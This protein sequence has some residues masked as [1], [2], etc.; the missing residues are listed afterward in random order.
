MVSALRMVLKSMLNLVRPADSGV[1]GVLLGQIRAQQILQLGKLPMLSDAGFCVT[2]QTDED[3]I[4]SWLVDRLKVA[5]RTFIEFGVSHYREANTRY[6][7]KSR[8]W[9]GLVIDG[10]P[11]NIEIIRSDSVSYMRDLLAISAFITRDNINALIAQAG[12]GARVGLLSTDID[13][14]DYWVLERVDIEADIVVVEYNDFLGRLPV[15]VPYSPD[16]HRL[17]KSPHGTYWGASLAAFRHLLESRG[18]LFVG[19]NLIG[20]NAFF[21][22]RDHAKATRE[23]L[24]AFVAHPCIMREA[25][26]ADGNLAYK[27]YSAFAA[28]IGGLPL[29]RVDTGEQITV[30]D[31]IG[32]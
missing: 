1:T 25:R 7:L 18:Y 11:K 26:E 19:T 13:G 15:S 20:V 22:H 31:A 2:S 4:L 12:F 16:F 27:P 21:V 28:E 32:A 30:A 5:N 14:V 3:G 8:N 10:D 29:V 6:L 9:R 17:S 23:W 24:D